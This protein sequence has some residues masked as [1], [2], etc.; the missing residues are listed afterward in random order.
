MAEAAGR[1][2]E[3]DYRLVGLYVGLFVALALV[4]LACWRW[5]VAAEYW[6]CYRYEKTQDSKYIGKL[7]RLGEKQRSSRVA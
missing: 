2:K 4:G 1:E 5:P 6:Y 7:A 3:R